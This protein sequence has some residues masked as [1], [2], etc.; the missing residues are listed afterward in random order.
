MGPATP[1]PR[2]HSHRERAWRPL[3]TT[4]LYE[5]ADLFVLTEFELKLIQTFMTRK[6]LV[7]V[8][9]GVHAVHKALCGG[10]GR[11]GCCVVPV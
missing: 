11:R 5:R 1:F 3:A 4:K 7:W 10:V 9:A 2:N 8:E 6:P